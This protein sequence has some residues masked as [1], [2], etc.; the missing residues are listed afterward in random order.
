MKQS[1]RNHPWKFGESFTSRGVGKTGQDFKLKHL[2]NSSGWASFSRIIFILDNVVLSSK[3][4]SIINKC[5]VRWNIFKI[6]SRLYYGWYFVILFCLRVFDSDIF[7]PTK[8]K[9]FEIE[10]KTYFYCIISLQVNLISHRPKWHFM[11]INFFRNAFDFVHV[12]V[13]CKRKFHVSLF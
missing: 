5:L 10:Y 6:M 1:A 3:N 4:D 11:K 7:A 8:K 2:K 9:R 12:F 13:R